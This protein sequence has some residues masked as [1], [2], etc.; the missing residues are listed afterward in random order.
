MPMKPCAVTGCR[1]L[2]PVGQQRCAKHQRQADEERWARAEA[3][4]SNPEA[5][6][7]YSWAAWRGPNGRRAMQLRKE[8]HCEMCPEETRQPA[9]VADHVQPHRGDH[10]RFWFGDLQSLC[11]PCHDRTK[12]R[13]EAQAD[14][15]GGVQG[16]RGGGSKVEG[17]GPATGGYS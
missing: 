5:R 15:R 4:R 17:R 10:A 9:T 7:W 3:V 14:R 6:R 2:V 16:R 1:S 8:P 12:Q 11:K 13:Q